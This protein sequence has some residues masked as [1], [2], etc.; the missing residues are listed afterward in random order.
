MIEQ[1]CEEMIAKFQ[2]DPAFHRKLIFSG[3]CVFA[4]TSSVNKHNVH[5][6]GTKEP[7]VRFQYP[8]KT[9]TLVVWAAIGYGDISRETMT[10]DR[11]CQ[12][13]D[14]KVVPCILSTQC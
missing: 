14:T 13:L 12:I 6:W 9:P 1:F 8:G 10:S 7:H 4:L 3:E 5:Y 2:A 11:Y